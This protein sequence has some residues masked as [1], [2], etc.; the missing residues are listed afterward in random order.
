MEGVGVEPDEYIEVDPEQIRQYGDPV[1]KKAAYW[2]L[3]KPGGPRS[4]IR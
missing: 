1:L 2:I 4:Q 3:G